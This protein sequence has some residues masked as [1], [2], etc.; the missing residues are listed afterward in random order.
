MSALLSPPTG[1]TYARAVPQPVEPAN[2]DA[3]LTRR[4][5]GA[6]PARDL[7]AEEHFCRRFGPRIRLF[8][9]KRLRSDAA[10]ADLAQDVLILVLDKLRAGAV[11]EPAQIA[12]FVFGVA[13]Q[14]VIDTRRNTERRSR[15]VD[16]FALDLE[17]AEDSDSPAEDAERLRHCLGRLAERERA[18]LVMTFYDD[19]PAD[20]LGSQL[21]IS[22]GN[23]R[24]IRHRGIERLR[25]CVQGKEPAP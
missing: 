15:L 9:L 10:A 20:R 5:L 12:S 7:Q 8:G 22:P 16:T 14:L 23:V 11:R 25:A 4:I 13:R 21:G 3:E 2:D 1:T 6:S 18:V 17:P 19:C 24:V